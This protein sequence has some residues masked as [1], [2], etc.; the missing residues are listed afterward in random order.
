LAKTAFSC[1]IGHL[2]YIVCIVFCKTPIIY[3]PNRPWHLTLYSFFYAIFSVVSL[4][5]TQKST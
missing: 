2:P 4:N 3:H 5:F 1:L